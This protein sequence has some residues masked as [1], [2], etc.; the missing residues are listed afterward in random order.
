[1]EKTEIITK[2]ISELVARKELH[3]KARR[4]H[5]QRKKI[6]DHANLWADAKFLRALPRQAKANDAAG[7]EAL[8]GQNGKD[9]D[10]AVVAAVREKIELLREDKKLKQHIDHIEKSI[11]ENEDNV[12]EYLLEEM[13]NVE[14]KR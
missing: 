8:V 6:R 11:D 14:K 7:L 10:P 13:L 12:D 5:A 3:D 4:L 1:M 9:W 2:G